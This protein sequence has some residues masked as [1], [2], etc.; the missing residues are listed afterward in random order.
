MALIENLEGTRLELIFDKDP[1]YRDRYGFRKKLSVEEYNGNLLAQL[2]DW[3]RQG[4]YVGMF[5]VDVEG[6]YTSIPHKRAVIAVY[7]LIKR[8]ETPDR[9]KAWDLPLF[10]ANWLDSRYVY[11]QKTCVKMISGVIQGGPFSPPVF[12][13]YFSYESMDKS[14]CRVMIFADDANLILRSETPEGL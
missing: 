11:F 4:L 5:S 14:I 3:K 7:E 2:E 12:L 8:A 6:A 9:D 10:T 1:I 13:V